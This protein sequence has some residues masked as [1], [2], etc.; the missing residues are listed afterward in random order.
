[1]KPSTF[2]PRLR[3]PERPWPAPRLVPGFGCR[4]A[5]HGVA[6][7]P[8]RK[9]HEVRGRRRAAE[10][11]FLD[12]GV[13]AGARLAPA[14]DFSIGPGARH[15]ADGADAGRVPQLAGEYA[16]ERQPGA[17]PNSTLPDVHLRVRCS[18][19]RPSARPIRLLLPDARRRRGACTAT[20]SAPKYYSWYHGQKRASAVAPV[21]R[22]R[23]FCT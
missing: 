23:S 1:M 4:T 20:C 5:G 7:G 9:G 14:R 10:S 13:V 8:G 6:T 19:G 11:A 12:G 15:R 18:L 17:A 16:A 22:L 21:A 3:S 2:K